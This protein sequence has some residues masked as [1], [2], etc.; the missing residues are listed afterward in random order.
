MRTTLSLGLL[1]FISFAGLQ[2][3]PAAPASD[4]NHQS[5]DLDT[6]QGCLHMDQSQYVLTDPDGKSHLLSGAARQLGRLVHHEVELGGK[7]GVRT[8][9]ATSVGGGS[10]VTEYVVFEVKTVKDVAAECKS[11]AK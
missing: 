11:P 1:L 2:A 10:S 3:E 4:K 7:T 5:A 6:M 9:D 8:S